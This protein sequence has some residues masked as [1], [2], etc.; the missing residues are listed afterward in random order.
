MTVSAEDNPVV[1]IILPTYNRL[2]W[3]LKSI[4]SVMEQSIK[5]WE[6]LVID[7]ISSD[8]TKE[9]MEELCAEDKR[10]KYHRLPV[11]KEPGISKFL[12]FGINNSKGKYIARLDDDDRWCDKDKLAKQVGFMEKNT[13]YVLVG[14][15]VIAINDKEE[16]IFRYLENETDEAIRKK[17]LL[18]NPMTHP[19]VLFRKD[20]AVNIGGYN[21]LAYAE[22]WD[23][24]LRMGTYGKMYNFPEYFAYYLMAGQNISLRNQRGAAR[25]IFE[26]LRAH[27]NNYPNY[28]KGYI[29]NCFQY[30]HSFTPSFFRKSTT[31]F[32]KYI[33]RK[34]F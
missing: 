8:G 26:I 9:K 11:T 27:K 17:A 6:L 1:S 28:T 22:D 29:V 24:W 4:N 30:C 31:T 2:S 21:K 25:M 7:D 23:F 32:L 20:V 14:G 19:T 33:K 16:E 3:L 15:G 12:N 18:S 5:N 10:I 34:Y 13:E